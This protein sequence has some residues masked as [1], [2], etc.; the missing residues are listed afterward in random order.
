MNKQKEYRLQDGGVITASCA[1]EFVT[2]LRESSKF[3]SHL[4]DQE[5]ME[6]FAHRQNIASGAIVRTD[7]ASNFMDDLKDIGYIL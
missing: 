1:S 7:T 5:Y 3:D 2:R 4:S 6:G